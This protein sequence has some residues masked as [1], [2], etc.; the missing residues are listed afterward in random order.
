MYY[1]ESVLFFAGCGQRIPLVGHFVLEKQ[2]YSCIMY[3]VSSDVFY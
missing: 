2:L 3:D 1:Y